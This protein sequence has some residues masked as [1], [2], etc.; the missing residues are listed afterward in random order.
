L[1]AIDKKL[2][3]GSFGEVYHGVWKG[4]TEVEVAVKMLKQG[5]LK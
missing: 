3:I 5:N 1:L 2:G 4:K